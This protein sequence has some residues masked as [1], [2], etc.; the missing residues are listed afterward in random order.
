MRKRVAAYLLVMAVAV[1]AA[2][3]CLWFALTSGQREVLRTFGGTE[4]V[5][6][7]KNPTKVEAFRLGKLPEGM[8]LHEAGL[9]DYPIT[10]GPF[11]VPTE[12][13][14]SITAALLDPDSY[15]WLPKK[16]KPK[17]GVRVAFHGS[18]G[19]IDILLCFECDYLA[20]YRDGEPVSGGNFDYARAELVL[21]AKAI[22]PEDE[23]IQSLAEDRHAGRTAEPLPGNDGSNR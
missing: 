7:L 18:G 14:Q 15:V 9:E 3:V 12:I 4:S 6:I 11:S 20:S 10:A 21:A 17:Y 23:V 1:A 8:H 2:G 19:R 13:A 16:C 5:R 22:F